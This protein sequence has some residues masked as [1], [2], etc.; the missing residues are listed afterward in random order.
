MTLALTEI[1]L[2]TVRSVTAWFLPDLSEYPTLDDADPDGSVLALVL[3]HLAPL[4]ESISAALAAVPSD[5]V[6]AHMTA[7]QRKDDEEFTLLRT[8]C[9]GWYLTCRPVWSTLGY[10]GR[11]AT[12]IGPGEAEHFLR[13]DILA[14]VRVRG[15]IFRPA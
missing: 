15:K 8:L 13:D 9:L 3:S 2:A 5:D 6:D 7:L 12:P 14:P 1:E 10:T 11:V 4:G